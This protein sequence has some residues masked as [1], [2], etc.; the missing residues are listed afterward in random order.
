MQKSKYFKYSSKAAHENKKACSK[1]RI[2]SNP[3]VR[4]KIYKNKAAKRG[5]IFNL[6]ESTATVLFNSP[7][8]YCGTT[9]EYR[10]IDRVANNV[11][12]ID[13]NCV[14][15]CWECNKAKGTMQAS[16]FI[17]M[18]KRVTDWSLDKKMD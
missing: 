8:H 16:A 3:F 11:G 2:Y 1:S 15:S 17:N 12:Y 6:E 9:F 10:G 5:L 7:C 18:C 4:Y 13:S 14:S